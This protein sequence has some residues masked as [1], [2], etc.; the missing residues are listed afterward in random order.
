MSSQRGRGRPPKKVNSSPEPSSADD[1]AVPLLK[2]TS[3][4]NTFK[5]LEDTNFVNEAGSME[6]IHTLRNLIEPSADLEES[7]I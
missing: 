2:Q 5:F 7:K 3:S 4:T 6:V 1:G